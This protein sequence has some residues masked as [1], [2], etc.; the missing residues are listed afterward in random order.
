MQGQK[1]FCKVKLTVTSNQNMPD[2]E[3]V[4]TFAEDDDFEQDEKQK[5]KASKQMSPKKRKGDAASDEPVRLPNVVREAAFK[6]IIGALTRGPLKGFPVR[7]VLVRVEKLET[8]EPGSI[9][10]S[11]DTLSAVR[12]ACTSCVFELYTKA[13]PKMMEPVFAFEATVPEKD[14]GDVLGDLTGRRRADIISVDPTTKERMIIKARVPA[15]ELLAY[16]KTL[17]SLTAGHGAFSAN[18]DRYVIVAE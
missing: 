5:P 12:N 3:P 10:P 9:S 1:M 2:A 13:N 8:N 4:V 6:G 7:G 17:R 15:I 14:L 18:F 16:S 11:E